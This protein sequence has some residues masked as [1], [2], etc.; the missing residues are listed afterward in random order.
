MFLIADSGSTKTDW[1]LV[2]QNRQI[3]QY[4]SPG[5]NPSIH[6]AE[7]IQA[8]LQ[9]ELLPQLGAN[10]EEIKQIFFYGAGC[11]SGAKKELVKKQLTTCFPNAVIEVNHDL[12]AAAR[13]VCGKEEGLVAILG[14][15]AS[16][17]YYDGHEIKERVPSLGYVLGDEGS[18]AHLGKTFLQYYLYNELPG[19]LK[20]K[21]DRRFDLSFE[22]LMDNVYKESSPNR[23]LASFSLFIY[24]NISHE[25]MSK[26]VCSCFE[27]FFENQILKYHNS[28]STPLRCVGSV[29][30]YYSN[31]LKRVGEE[32]GVNIDRVLEK[33]IA[34]LT[35]YHTGNTE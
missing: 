22:E 5:I 34:G 20:Q 6:Q 11:S 31:L 35:L 14:T 9:N 21:F 27:E 24:Q 1:R 13:A 3:S 4:K 18:G 16:S 29:A 10:I 19:D 15:G 30:F 12:L 28:G 26:M 17:C 8:S 33:P 7:S 2:D 23:F 25:F 32:K